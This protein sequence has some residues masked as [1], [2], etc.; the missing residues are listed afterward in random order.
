MRIRLDRVRALAVAIVVATAVLA[1]PG[2]AAASA[3]ASTS[4][5][6]TPQVSGNR[7][8]DTRTG[9]TWV[10]HAVNWPS[11]EYACQ[12]GWAYA[13]AGRTSAAAAAMA[14]WGINAVR[15]PLNEDCWLG[16]DGQPSFGSAS[17]YRAAVRA[18]VDLLTANGLVVILDLHWSGGTGLVAGGQR[19]FLDDQ[20]PAFWRSVA[21]DYAASP[22]VMFDAFNEPYSTG[23]YR[24]TWTCWTNGGCAMPTAL[25]GESPGTTTFT[26]TGMRDAIG[27]IRGAGA[28]QPVLLGGLDYA[29][30][31]TGWLAA[32]AALGDGQLVASWHNYPAQQTRGADWVGDWN[33][34]AAPVAAK[35]PVIATEFAQTDG[36]TDFLTAFMTWA[37]ARGI[38]YAPWAWWWTDASDGP[39][40][41]AYALI[42]N[43]SFAPR[44]PQGTAYAAHLRTLAGSPSTPPPPPPPAPIWDANGRVTARTASALVTALYQDVLH[45]TPDAGG[46]AYWVGALLNGLPVSS[47]VNGVLA[48]PEYYIARVDAAY[49]ST[50]GR[51]ADAAGLNYW[52][53]QISSGALPVD[54]VQMTLTE[55]DEFAWMRAGGDPVQFAYVLYRTL[56][57]RAPSAGEA[58]YWSWA[59]TQY[60]RAAVV[61]SIYDSAESGNRRV[62][63]LYTTYF[64]RHADGGGLAYWTPIVLAQGDQSLRGQLVNSPEYV[65]NAVAR[66]PNG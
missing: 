48:S 64:Q 63:A 20:S 17:G 8:V 16:T 61:V 66:Y 40:A 19:P 25:D 22:S 15:L 21:S 23:S 36:G 41:N 56:L 28:R 47:A 37:D 31:L 42:Q 2:T 18:W 55:S 45:R 38:G 39:E 9:A 60:G 51:H 1:A 32:T 7:L 30:D 62:D 11:F 4:T 33:A 29:H 24:L 53:G 12:Q 46:R 26:T 14:S 34:E 6:P 44:A 3:A 10:A 27:A 65:V 54:Q 13:Q 59:V 43:G 52:L 57:G 50:L 35:V 5:A 49:V 58:E